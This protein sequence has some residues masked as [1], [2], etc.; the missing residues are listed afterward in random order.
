VLRVFPSARKGNNKYRYYLSSALLHG[1]PDRAGSVRRISAA[2]IEALVAETVRNH[3][4][5][6]APTD[7]RSLVDAY[8][9]R[10]EVQPARLVIRLTKGPKANGKRA[11][12]ERILQ[13]PWQKKP[14]TTR[15]EI[16]LPDGV[17]GQQARP[18]GWPFRPTEIVIA[19]PW[20]TD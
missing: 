15:R 9:A 17:S 5:E 16:L 2:E 13:V 4:K 14:A 6:T 12:T 10:V 7:D 1:T 20:A 8:V 18:I 11:T 19:G 3:I